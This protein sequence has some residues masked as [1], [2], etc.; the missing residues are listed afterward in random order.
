M[1]L[2]V[3]DKLSVPRTLRANGKYAYTV[4][5]VAHIDQLPYY[6]LRGMSYATNFGNPIAAFA[7]WP[8]S[9]RPM[10]II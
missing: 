10:S 6:Y 3:T 4:L 8:E 9:F 2:L 5:C 1:S 7:T